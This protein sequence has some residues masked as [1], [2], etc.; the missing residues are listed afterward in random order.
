MIGT[1]ASSESVTHAEEHDEPP[2]RVDS[3]LGG[4]TERALIR[5]H[6]VRLTVRDNVSILARNVAALRF[7]APRKHNPDASGCDPPRPL[8]LAYLLERSGCPHDRR[9]SVRS[10]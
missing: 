8:L 4:H 9:N 2:I 3:A 5:N 7:I 10:R 6:I 1:L